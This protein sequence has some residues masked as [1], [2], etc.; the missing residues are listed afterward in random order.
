MCMWLLFRPSPHLKF[1]VGGKERIER[2]DISGFQI[3]NFIYLKSVKRFW[4]F[5][6]CFVSRKVIIP[7][8]SKAANPNTPISTPDFSMGL[9]QVPSD[10]RNTVICILEILIQKIHIT[11]RYRE[12]PLIVMAVEVFCLCWV[13]FFHTYVNSHNTAHLKMPIV[14]LLTSVFYWHSPWKAHQIHA[15]AII[16]H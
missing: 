8:H 3:L 4:A 11:S 15:G 7:K 16:K 10:D 13:T 12:L 6:M 14:L 1:R 2:I 5:W 9:W